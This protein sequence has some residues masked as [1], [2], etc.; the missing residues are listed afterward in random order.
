MAGGLLDVAR[1]RLTACWPGHDPGFNA[2]ITAPGLREVVAKSADSDNSCRS[3]R[4]TSAS[5]FP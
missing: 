4:M 1:A 2:L 5:S 3:A